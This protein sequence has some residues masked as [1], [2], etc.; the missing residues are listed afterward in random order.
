[1]SKQH[2]IVMC[3]LIMYTIADG[4]TAGDTVVRERVI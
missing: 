4:A 1:M 2:G 3:T